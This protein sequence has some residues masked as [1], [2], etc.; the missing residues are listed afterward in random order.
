MRSNSYTEAGSAG[1]TITSESSAINSKKKKLSSLLSPSVFCLFFQ[2]KNLTLKIE[3][4]TQKRI[5]TQ[6]DL[7]AQNQQLNSL[8]TSEKQLKQETNHLLDIKRSLEKQNQE[9]RKSVHNLSDCIPST[10]A[11]KTWTRVTRVHVFIHRERQETDGQMKELQDQL[12]AEQYFSVSLHPAIWI[13][14]STTHYSAESCLLSV[15]AVM[16]HQNNVTFITATNAR[17]VNWKAA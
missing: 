5:L 8:R 12:E 16:C 13:Q 1:R 2:V 11:F 17:C 14:M 6:N 10:Q 7:K 9:L 4:E 3:Q 15:W